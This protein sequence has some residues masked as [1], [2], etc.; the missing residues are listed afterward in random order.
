MFEVDEK[1]IFVIGATNRPDTLDSAI[2]RPG[3]LD[4]LIYIPLPDF[5]SRTQILKSNLRKTPLDPSIN[6]DLIAQHTDGFSGA[7]LSEICQ[8]ACKL[9]IKDEIKNEMEIED[10]QNDECCIKPFHF[11]EA[12]KYARRSVTDQSIRTYEMFAHT[13]NQS[14]GMGEFKFNNNTNSNDIDNDDGLYD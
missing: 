10:Y 6:L 1:N 3:R 9:A 7:D 4:Q 12:M 5:E 8:R 13:L 2:L 11:E 14:R